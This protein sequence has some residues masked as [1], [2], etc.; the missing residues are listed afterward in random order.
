M[1]SHEYMNLMCVFNEYQGEYL[2]IAWG[3]KLRIKCLSDIGA[4]QTSLTEEDEDY[5]GEYVAIVTE[6]VVLH[7][8]NDNAIIIHNDGIEINLTTIPETITTEDGTV[9]WQRTS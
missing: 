2:L 3:N 6:V 1:N 5:V 8:G 4:F 7:P 9:V